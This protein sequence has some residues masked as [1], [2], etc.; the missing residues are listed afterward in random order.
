M[1]KKKILISL[2]IFLAILSVLAVR[3]YGAYAS[4]TNAS[5]VWAWAVT[6]W[7]E[8]RN[9]S[10]DFVTDSSFLKNAIAEEGGNRAFLDASSIPSR[11]G[12]RPQMVRGVPHRQLD[13]HPGEEMRSVMNLRLSTLHDFGDSGARRISYSP[14]LWELTGAQA[15]IVK[16]CTPRTCSAALIRAKGEFAHL[17][18]HDGSF[19]VQL[20]PKDIAFV[21]ESGWG[22][23]F[24][25]SGALWGKIPYVV[26]V[27]APRTKGESDIVSKVLIASYEYATLPSSENSK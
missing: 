27:Y 23:L 11:N 13:Q 10:M 2:A 20:S 3:D 25:I 22:E 21:I 24:P 18:S 26:L 12:N 1:R 7:L 16:D 4:R 9:P 5:A 14:S 8:F 6:R 17:H 19:H 15:L